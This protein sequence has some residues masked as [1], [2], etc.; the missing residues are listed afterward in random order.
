MAEF[1][2][3]LESI[4]AD[5][6]SAQRL[7]G[8]DG[9]G[10]RSSL[11]IHH[12]NYMAQLAEAASLVADVFAGKRPAHRLQEAMTTSDFPLLFG[13][14]I[15]RQLL[16]N[17][18]ETPA[19]YK[20]FCK[21]GTVRDFRTVNRFTMDGAEGVLAE[22]GQQ[23]PYPDTRLTEGRY[24][25]QVKKYGR[26]IPFSWEAM[27]ND[28]LDALKDIPQ[29][30][31]RAARRT[32]AKFA[33][34]LYCDANGPHASFYTTGNKNRIHT[35]NG[36]ST[37]NPPLSVGA[38]QQALIVLSKMVDADGEPIVIETVEL[39]VPPALQVTAQNI[40]NGL[41]LELTEAGG[42]ST[43]KL[44][45]ANWM[46]NQLR[47]SVDPYIPIV[48]TTNGNT[49]WFLFANPSVSR[50]AIEIAFLRGHAE[51]EVFMKE[52]NARR[53]GG[54][55]DPMNGDFDTDSIEYKIRHCLGGTRMDPKATVAS[56]GTGS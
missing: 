3:L 45:V 46:K 49:S 56:N 37:A 1:L 36:A 50:P 42:T 30:F 53:V 22:V 23:A 27:I 19:V 48:A 54:G 10:V 9:T 52:P 33:T 21:I 2:E 55:T 12:P 32:E 25:L 4:R 5:Q 39:V 40:L 20:N 44:I 34:T 14:I 41:Q 38:L 8:G 13:D 7:F 43:Q 31:G 11:R 29:R 24:Q 18:R 26:R 17:Y 28:D 16:A 51:P 15:D 6:A 35:E 47:L